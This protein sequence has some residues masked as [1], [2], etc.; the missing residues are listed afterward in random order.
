MPARWKTIYHA[1]L[2]GRLNTL[3]IFP[4]YV[5]RKL[6]NLAADAVFDAVCM[7]LSGVDS[8]TSRLAG[9]AIILVDMGKSEG[10][11]LLVAC[12]SASCKIACFMIVKELEVVCAST[13][14]G[15]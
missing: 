14:Y 12:K 3:H 11:A 1:A 4:A 2:P 6:G 13:G 8:S 5:K 7:V 9:K 10:F 15:G